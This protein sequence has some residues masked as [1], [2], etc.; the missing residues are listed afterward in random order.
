MLRSIPESV[1]PLLESELGKMV[2]HRICRHLLARTGVRLVSLHDSQDR[3]TGKGSIRTIGYLPKACGCSKSSTCWVTWKTR[4]RGY[5]VALPAIS[6]M[7]SRRNL[8]GYGWRS[9]RYCIRIDRFRNGMTAW[10]SARR[11]SESTLSS[12]KLPIT[13][14]NLLPVGSAPSTVFP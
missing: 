13:G 12:I 5:P 10:T 2:W 11:G 14:T 7:A 9:H 8:A 3:V 4:V 6:R 1:A